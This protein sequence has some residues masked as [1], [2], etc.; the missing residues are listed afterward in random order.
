MSFQLPKTTRTTPLHLNKKSTALEAASHADLRTKTVV[1]TGANTGIGKETAL[2][3]ASRGARVVCAVR[4]IERMKVA[5]GEIRQLVPKARIEA[6]KLDLGDLASV[7]AFAEE[8]LA[9]ELP[10]HIL[11]LNAGVFWKYNYI[12]KSGFEAHFGTNHVGHFYLVQLLRQRLENSAPSRVVV[13]SSSA[14]KSVKKLDLDDLNVEWRYSGFKAY[15]QSKLCNLLFAMELNAQFKRMGVKA[16]C[17]AVHPGVIKTEIFRN[18]GGFVKRLIHTVANIFGKSIPQGAATTVYAAVSDEVENKGGLYLKNCGI[19]KPSH[20]SQKE[21]LARQLW[22]KTEE[23]LQQALE[24]EA[25]EGG[26]EVEEMKKEEKG[27]EEEEVA[28]PKKESDQ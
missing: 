11:I 14:H 7:R 9:K 19:G 5:M 17:N 2:A 25:K 24:K 10:L 15:A 8:F 12:V 23:M 22:V 6:M 1:I 21:G 20:Y 13:L 26:G 16:T 27:G 18:A 28:E 4:S 3:L